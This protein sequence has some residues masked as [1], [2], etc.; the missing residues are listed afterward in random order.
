M[1]WFSLIK[2]HR[3]MT[4]WTTLLMELPW[5]EMPEMSLWSINFFEFLWIENILKKTE[6]NRHTLLWLCSICSHWNSDG[7]K[8]N[9]APFIRS[10][11]SSSTLQSS[12][13]HMME[14]YHAWINNRCL[15]LYVMHGSVFQ[16]S[17]FST[18]CKFNTFKS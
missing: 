10:P 13:Q 9:A 6:M 3:L 12:G 14:S 11:L 1:Q 17:S 16:K 4:I 8:K 18:C 7:V 5:L 2:S 15:L